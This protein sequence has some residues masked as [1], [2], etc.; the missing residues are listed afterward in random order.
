M[1]RMMAASEDPRWKIENKTEE[2][3]ADLKKLGQ[4]MKNARSVGVRANN[5]A[6]AKL[7]DS[8]INLIDKQ[9]SL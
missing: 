7:A 9:V 2:E 4:E 6:A 1:K 5:G 8:K 3:L